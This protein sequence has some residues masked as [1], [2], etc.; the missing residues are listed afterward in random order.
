MLISHD[1]FFLLVDI[2]LNHNETLY[3]LDYILLLVVNVILTLYWDIKKKKDC[4][5]H[6]YPNNILFNK[7]NAFSKILTKYNYFQYNHFL[8]IISIFY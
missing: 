8:K 6:M 3:F 5:L 1:P 7:E 4:S 2:N